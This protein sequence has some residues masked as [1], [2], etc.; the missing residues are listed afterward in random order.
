[1]NHDFHSG[2]ITNLEAQVQNALDEDVG[3]GDRTAELIPQSLEARA[4][5]IVREN[6]V[7]CGQAWFEA[8]FRLVDGRVQVEW[9]ACEGAQ[10][11]AGQPVVTVWGP[12]RALLTAERTALNFLQTLS[13]VATH[14]R[15]FVDA[16]AGTRAR[17]VDTRKT[18]PG[19]RLAEK[20]AVRVGGGTNHRIGLFDGILIKENHVAAAGGIRQA[21]AAA[22]QA[23]P[24][25]VFVQ[26]EVETLD[27]LDQALAAGAPMILLDNM[28][29]AQQHE[30]VRRTAGRA[31][32]E[33]SGGVTLET[34]RAIAATGVDR[35]SVGGL[36]KDIKAVDFSMRFQINEQDS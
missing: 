3:S 19:L 10:L 36:T 15:Q 28:A 22:L 30:A 13:G 29:R 11:S 8:A 16:V 1:M 23:A 20:Y 14:T 33:A 21:V 2:F 26:V 24:A 18:L 5:V 35:I 12:A 9:H 4:Q 7:L 17:I 25:G 27:E 32:L 34:V 31:S 6:A